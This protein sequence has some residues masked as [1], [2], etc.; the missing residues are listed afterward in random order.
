M[1]PDTWL[2][3]LAGALIVVGVLGTFLPVLP[4]IPLVFSGM[5]LAAW[6]GDFQV[7]SGWTLLF[8]GVLAAC[9]LAIDFVASAL[10]AKK[11]GAS[12]K[13][14]WGA[15]LGTLFGLLLGIPGL[16][17]GP[18]AGA[19]AGELIHRGALNRANMGEAAKIG[20]ATWIGMAVGAALKL[21]VAFGMLGLFAL[22]IWLP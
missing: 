10:G 2:Y 5:L 8:L 20:A 18:F 12:P 4:G 17:I 13:A 6:V 15:A 3:V 11:L 16:I 14:V 9:A 1:T 7:I 21:A 19:V 22:A